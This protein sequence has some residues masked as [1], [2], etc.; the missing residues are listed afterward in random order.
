MHQCNFVLRNYKI[1][2]GKFKIIFRGQSGNSQNFLGKF[3]RIFVTLGL[4]YNLEIIKPR[5]TF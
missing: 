1:D 5:S 3:V 4:I 2:A